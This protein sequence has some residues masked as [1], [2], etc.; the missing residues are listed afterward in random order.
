MKRYCL[1][2]LLC[3]SCLFQKGFGQCA[4]VFTDINANSAVCGIYGDG[5]GNSNWNWEITDK[6][7]SSYCNMWYSRT[8]SISTKLTAM[9]SPFVDASTSALDLISQAQDFTRAKGWELVR[10]DFGCS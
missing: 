10:R 3:V 1:A 6:T 9:G 7:N 8:S 5:N 4:D 2:L